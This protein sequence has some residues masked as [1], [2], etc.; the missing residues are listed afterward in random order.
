MPSEM[1]CEAVNKIIFAEQCL[2]LN[3]IPDGFLAD[4]RAA[5]PPYLDFLLRTFPG[6]TFPG[7][8]DPDG[9]IHFSQVQLH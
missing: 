1:I 2:A 7:R 3:L 8:S 9:L 6:R 4:P 5:I